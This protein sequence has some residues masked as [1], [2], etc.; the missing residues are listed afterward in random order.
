VTRRCAQSKEFA[1]LTRCCSSNFANASD[2]APD[3][4]ASIDWKRFAELARHH[5]VQGFAW[6]GLSKAVLPTEVAE[7]L[8]SDARSIAATNLA[9]AR[10]CGEL[11]ETF[12]GAGVPLIFLKGLTVGALAYRNPLLKMGWDIDL[13]IDPADL[14][15]AGGLLASRGFELREPSPTELMKWHHWSK[16]SVWMRSDGV[17]VELHTRLAD[18][19]RLIPSL[20]LHSP[21]QP[22]EVMPGITLATFANDELFAYLC[23][24]GASSAWFR[25]KWI[26][27]L[28]GLIHGRSGSEIE[29]LWRRS[30]GLGAHRA[31]AQALLV[32]DALFGSMAETSLREELAREW[33]NRVLADAALRQITGPTR[34][35]TEKPLGT[36]RI[37]WTQLLLK[38]GLGFAFNEAG[39]QIGDL[40]HR[41]ATAA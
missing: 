18:N 32:A 40:L 22:V 15:S 37:H 38:R 25:L 33:P 29:C 2:G 7:A 9:I 6:N 8:S 23:V 13:L 24:H 20:D 21:T 16:E 28:A 3:V 27:D 14:G 30:Q 11:S 31:A 35:P 41:R 26:S 39:R 1:L 10:E 36:L 12:A 5:R 34:E 17:H 4:A 19:R